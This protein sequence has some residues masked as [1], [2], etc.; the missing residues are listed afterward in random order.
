MLIS[1]VIN[2]SVI[3]WSVGLNPQVGRYF[4]FLLLM[5]LTSFASVAMG[6]CVSALSPSAVIAHAVGSPILIVL[7]LFSECLADCALH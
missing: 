6:F 1:A 5:V 2:A 3:Y 7:L 4:T